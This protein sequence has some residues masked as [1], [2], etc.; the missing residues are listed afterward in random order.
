L[1]RAYQ[2][3]TPRC[4]NAQFGY[5]NEPGGWPN[6]SWGRVGTVGTQKEASTP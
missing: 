2:N 4:A 6:A 5:A 3:G 1:K